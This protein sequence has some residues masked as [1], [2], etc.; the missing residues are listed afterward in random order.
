M[1]WLIRALTSGIAAFIAT[2]IDGLLILMLF[3]SQVNASFRKRHIVVGQYLGF[4]A[5]ILASLPGFFGRLIVPPEWIGLLGFV[6]I[7][8][9]VKQLVSREETESDVQTVATP[10][11]KKLSKTPLQAAFASLVSP[12]T[13]SVA[14]VTIANGGDNIGIYVPL[15]AGQQLASLGVIL[16]VFYIMAGIWCY[17][18]Y[19]LSSHR[20][21]AHLLSRYGNALVPYVMIGLG[22][23]ILLDND[24]W[25]LV[26]RH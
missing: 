26:V 14:A 25:K 11:D 10:P 24:S 20:A 6:P 5:L 4:T 21:I 7:A 9:G 18:A 17:I 12:Q 3:F 8:M 2:N 19:Q 13:Y 22:I 16:G 1:N 23:F 15:F